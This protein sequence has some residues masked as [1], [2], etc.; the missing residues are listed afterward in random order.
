MAVTTARNYDVSR[1]SESIVK[2]VGEV[3]RHPF[4]LLLIGALTTSLLVPYLNSK[5][6]RNQLLREARLKK[7]IEIGNHNTEFN[8]RFNALKT[9]LE[10][11]HNQNV[12]LRL[13]PA[14]LRQA[15]LKFRDD[16]TKRYLDLDE[17]AWWWHP[18]I[19]R[20]ASVLGLI[21]SDELQE[22]DRDLKEY[23]NNVNKSFNVLRPLW[24]ELTSRDYNPNDLKSSDKVKKIV[25]ETQALNPLFEERSILIGRI[26]KH[27]TSMK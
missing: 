1:S 27:F 24:Q 8:S 17:I 22:L 2:Q 26:T 4:V 20:E 10:S 3:L 5:V 23:G 6:N 13:E 7:A 21:P 18:D 12:R 9:M 15:Q 19:E 11:F 14:E 25:A 16:F